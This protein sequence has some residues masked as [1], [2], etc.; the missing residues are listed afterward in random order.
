MANEYDL[1][2]A[3]G[4]AAYNAFEKATKSGLGDLAQSAVIETL[5]S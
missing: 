5:K 3:V 1:P 2:L 4:Q